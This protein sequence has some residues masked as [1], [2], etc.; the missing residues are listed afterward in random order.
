MGCPTT[1]NGYTATWTRGKLARL[2]K[3]VKLTG[4]HTYNYSYNAL[5]QRIGSSYAYTAGTTS[6]SVSLGMLTGCDKAYRYDQSGRLISEE[7]TNRYYGE[8]SVSEKIM[9][10]YDESGMI[11]MTL[12]GTSAA[13][14]YY[15]QRNLLGDVIAIYDTN[16]TKVG[17]YAYDAWGNCTITLNT[18]GVATRN[19]IRYRGY[20]YDQDTGLYFLNARYYSPAWRRFISPDD[21]AYLNPET[22]NGLNLYCY[23]NNDP[24]NYCDP[25]GNSIA[26]ALT[27]VGIFAVGFGS[28]LFINAAT[29]NWQLDW[30]DFAQ[31]G[32]DGLFAV[33]A[34]ALAMTGI[35]VG[36]SIGL[37]AAMGWSQ[38]AIGTKIQG[39]NLTWS[40]SITAIAFGALGGLISG[41]GATNAKN[42]AN[43]L[44]GLSDDGLRAAK[45][46]ATALNR[47]MAGQI[48]KRGFQG[49]INLYGKTAFSAIDTAITI[50]SEKLFKEAARNIAIYTP[51]ANMASGGLGYLYNVWGWI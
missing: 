50:T 13:G 8:D 30:R 37:G 35:G 48:S 44:T 49:V 16:G 43:H 45:A 47:R 39:G 20:Y 46:I 27:F 17:G 14:A 26:L 6:G 40:G 31:A 5:G 22:P 36:A 10:L 25:S 34:A 19:P 7:T 18:N 15:F 4:T 21:T 28:S 12:E 23:C 38:Y 42:I 9:F 33:G 24:V 2:S 11:G 32:I 1:V 3:G 41:A 51:I 29:N